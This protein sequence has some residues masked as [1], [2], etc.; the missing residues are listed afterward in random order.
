MPEFPKNQGQ[1][2]GWDIFLGN[3]KREKWTYE[4]LRNDVLAKGVKSRA[5]Y[6]NKAH[7]FKWPRELMLT[8]MPE[9]PKNQDGSN[10]WDTFLN[11]KS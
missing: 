6:Q 7:I 5:N 8:N 2:S 10:D 9:F 11:K 1:T 3:N 4:V